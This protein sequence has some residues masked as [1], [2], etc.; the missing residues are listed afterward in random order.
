MTKDYELYHGCPCP[1]CKKGR[2]VEATVWNHR[3]GILMCN[4]CFFTSQPPEYKY[5]K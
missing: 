5:K 1:S 4:S 3:E 2:L